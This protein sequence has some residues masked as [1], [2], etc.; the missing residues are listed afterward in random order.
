MLN[1]SLT[2]PL[3]NTLVGACTPHIKPEYKSRRWCYTDIQ[4]GRSFICTSQSP[5]KVW[6]CLTF[7]RIMWRNHAPNPFVSRF[8]M[9][10]YSNCHKILPILN[11]FSNNESCRSPYKFFSY[12]KFSE[13]HDSQDIWISFF[14]WN[15]SRKLVWTYC[16]VRNDIIYI[17]PQVLHV[18]KSRNKI[19][20]SVL[21]YC[22]LPSREL[23]Y[24]FS[25]PPLRVK[26][27][28]AV[29][30]LPNRLARLTL[31][32]AWVIYLSR[33][34]EVRD[35][36]PTMEQRSRIFPGWWGDS[37]NISHSGLNLST[38]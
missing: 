4:Y 13:T 15:L 33:F 10:F 36:P 7:L 8:Y 27:S 6:S 20:V 28:G 23:D 14:W 2:I 24:G 1:A 9:Y 37:Y 12:Q 21:S 34:F 5:E 22:I 25:L 32:S 11:L 29:I 16:L 18:N 17:F 26:S 19:K 38:L 31:L 3:L 35:H 30:D